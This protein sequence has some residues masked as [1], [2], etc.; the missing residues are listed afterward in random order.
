[1]PSIPANRPSLS[2]LELLAAAVEQRWPGATHAV[3]YYSCSD[4]WTLDGVEVSVAGWIAAQS[5]VE[6]YLDRLAELREEETAPPFCGSPIITSEV[7]ASISYPS[8]T[9]VFFEP[10]PPKE[11]C[12]HSGK[13]E[14]K[15]DTGFVLHNAPEGEGQAN[16]RLAEQQR[17]ELRFQ[18]VQQF[19]RTER[20]WPTCKYGGELSITWMYEQAYWKCS[21]CGE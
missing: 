19:K 1:M 18:A 14:F 10:A 2:K 13:R 16:V 12:A 9:G 17:N 5:T 7:L 21:T 3:N 8:M 4:L 6:E 15:C 20:A 11:R